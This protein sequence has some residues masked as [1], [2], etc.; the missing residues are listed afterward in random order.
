MPHL[1]TAISRNAEPREH[2]LTFYLVMPYLVLL[3]GA[4]RK[5]FI[6]HGHFL[7]GGKKYKE[8]ASIDYSTFMEYRESQIVP[9]R[10]FMRPPFFLGGLASPTLAH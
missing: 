2:G 9:A 5:R 10:R 4:L 7:P 8:Q 3:D 6:Y 1:G